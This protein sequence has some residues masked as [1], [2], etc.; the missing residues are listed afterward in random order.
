[1]AEVD[2]NSIGE[3]GEAILKVVLLTL[4][5]TR[6]L[7]RL[8]HLGEK[9]PAVDYLVELFG[10]PGHF[11]LIQVKT[12]QKGVQRNGRLKVRLEQ[13]KYNALASIPVP[14]YVVG[15]DNVSE[16]A[17]ICAVTIPLDRQRSSLS[18]AHSLRL[19][20]TRRMVAREVASFWKGV[21]RN[22]FR[23]SALLDK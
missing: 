10:R 5:G 11:F 7:F 21:G 3:R 20:S 16:E 14:R 15:I 19:T 2:A 4:H 1:M 12:T 17:Y 6:P 18:T 22:R 8:A 9:W 23:T 13:K